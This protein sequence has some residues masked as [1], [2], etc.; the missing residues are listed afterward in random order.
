MRFTLVDNSLFFRYSLPP[1]RTGLLW[2][3]YQSLSDL[4][5]AFRLGIRL[6]RITAPIKAARNSTSD[7]QK[8]DCLVDM[9]KLV[10]QEVLLK[11]VNMLFN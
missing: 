4:K 8:V 9:G 11:E 2:R 5:V 3:F 1:L 6:N 7:P 10:L